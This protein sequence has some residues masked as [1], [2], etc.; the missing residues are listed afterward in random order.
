MCFPS[1]G[2]TSINVFLSF[3]G[4]Q[5]YNLRIMTEGVIAWLCDSDGEGSAWMQL[6]AFDPDMDFEIIRTWITNER[7]HAMWCA[8]RFHYPLEK[9]DF[10]AV[11]FD[12]AQ[13]TGDV[14]F[15]ASADDDKAVGFFSYSM[16]PDS[17]EGKLKFV[18]V[19]PECRGKGVARQ[20]LHLAVSYAFEETDA[21]R[22]SLIVFSD[23]LRAKRCYEKA[24]FCGKE[25]D[26]K[27]FVYRDESW[28][29]CCMSISR[30]ISG[31]RI[32]A[33][34]GNDCSACPRYVSH[35]YE[36]TDT[37]LRHTAELWMKIGY[38]DHIV[39]KE[40][41]SCNGCKPGNWCRYHV[42]KCC[43]GK[44]IKTCAECDEYPCSNMKDCFSV[45]NS[46]EPKCREVCTAQEYESLK[47]A[48][49]EKEQN[50]KELQKDG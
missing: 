22:V 50:L 19:D 12:M 7:A 47:K 1:E 6:R 4:S 41:I 8:N 15:V 2:T 35:P 20:M 27:P 44:G 42:V 31:K 29:R 39:S 46:F 23:N 26:C 18:I 28:S 10:M 48:F 43:E 49:F 21:D 32:I 24:G 37:E 40:E 33:A 30:S 9:N 17:R 36:K 11:L 3:S 38:R 13:R 45:T 34:C 16:N 25:S 5:R 14:P